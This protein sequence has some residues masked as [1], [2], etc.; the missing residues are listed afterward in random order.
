MHTFKDKTGDE[1]KVEIDFGSHLDVKA[2]FGV[3]LLTLPDKKFAGWKALRGDDVLLFKVIFH[4]VKDQAAARGIA[5]E[6]GFVKRLCGQSIQDA[7]DAFEDE[8]L[9]FFPHRRAA[10]A[11]HKIKRKATEAAAIQME[12]AHQAIDAMTLESVTA[13]LNAKSG[14]SRES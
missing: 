1:W 4:L 7:I 9:D 12:K 13:T 10:E 3:D 2:A 6:R 14:E 5:D 8:L 11:L